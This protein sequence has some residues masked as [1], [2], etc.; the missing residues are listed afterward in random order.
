MEPE[1]LPSEYLDFYNKKS[2][3][4]NNQLALKKYLEVV[5]GNVVEDLDSAWCQYLQNPETKISTDLLKYDAL[6]KSRNYTP[7]TIIQYLSAVERYLRD[8]C[9]FELSHRQKRMRKNRLPKRVNITRDIALDSEMIKQIISGADARLRAEILIGCSGGLRISE[10]VGFRISDIDLT[11]SPV[12]LF[13]TANVAKNGIARL[14]YISDEA[15]DAV[16]AWLKIREMS[17]QSSASRIKNYSLNNESLFPYS[18][19]NEIFRL[20]KRLKDIGMYSR[21]E[22]TGRSKITFHSFRKFF[23]SQF[24][25]AGNPTVAEALTG[26]E[27]Y[28]D[29]S[30]R[31]IPEA[32]M[33]AEYLKA[34]PRLMIHVPEDYY[35]IKVE[36]ASEIAKLQISAADQ[37]HVINQL[38]DELRQLRKQQE[39]MS[40]TGGI[41]PRRSNTILQND[42]YE[43]A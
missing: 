30:Y 18:K 38:L 21:D 32:E 7:N 9:N 2:S 43:G 1:L 23:T 29:A 6:C 40:I 39:I 19:F 31:R 25:L 28:L 36:Q 34:M 5:T 27:G 14:T 37:Q 17:M 8:G 42:E 13:I 33:Q 24:K 26:H 4:Y 35:K 41:V 22:N 12:E 10:I 20:N 15:A 16:K 11:K 3:R